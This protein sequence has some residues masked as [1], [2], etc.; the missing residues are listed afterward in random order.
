M[1]TVDDAGVAGLQPGR[2]ARRVRRRCSNAIGDIFIVDLETGEVKNLT[3]DPFGDYAPDVGARRQVDRLHRA[4][5][6]QRQ[7]VPAGSPG[8]PGKKTQLTFGTHD[9]GA[10]QFLD[11]DTI[12]FPSTA[13]D[14]N[15][16]IDPEVA[17][18]GNIYN[19]WT[20]NLKN[21]EL[22]QYTDA[23]G[24]NVSPIVAAGRGQAAEDRVRHLL[25]G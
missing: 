8:A 1:K 7:A 21:G 9:D 16:P 23:L 18:N 24:G 15:Q 2:Q 22:K 3:N 14:P 19:I 5:Q 4:R 25:Q 17:R 13:V 20:L 6:R 10:A 12:V 11:A